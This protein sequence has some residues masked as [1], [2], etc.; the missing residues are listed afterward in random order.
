MLVQQMTRFLQ[1]QEQPH[2]VLK[3]YIT[4]AFDSVSWPYLLEV[5]QHLGFRPIW[6]DIIWGLLYSS[7]TQMLLNGIPGQRIFHW[8]GL[9]QGDPL[10]Q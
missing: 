6:R 8:R 10:L 9:R 7:T 5:M 4:K 2:L 1:Q 3:L